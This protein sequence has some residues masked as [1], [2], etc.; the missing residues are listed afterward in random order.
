[1]EV[2]VTIEPDGK[3]RIE[4]DGAVG[5]SCE[6]ITTALTE[7]LGGKTISEVKK[8]EYYDLPDERVPDKVA[9]K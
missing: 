9:F 2:T 1:M 7:A 6:D 3:S 8:P 5:G 4:V